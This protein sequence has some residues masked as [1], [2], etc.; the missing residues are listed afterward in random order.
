MSGR[1]ILCP[2]DPL[3]SLPRKPLVALLQKLDLMTEPLPERADDAF[4]AGPAFMRWIS[5]AGCSPFLRFE[6]QS[7]RDRDFCHLVLTFEEK[8]QL[9]HSGKFRPPHCG[10][11][12]CLLRDWYPNEEQFCPQC[13]Q[14]L[15]PKALRW[16]KYA[17]LGRSLILLENVF[18]NEGVPQPTLMNRLSQTFG[19][20]FRFFY[21]D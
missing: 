16:G 15:S 19:T 11:C 14:P 5:F 12:Q 20:G 21:A 1:L 8:P 7:P 3:C 4:A 10:H 18:P 9:R 6:P 13:G 2:Q 17:G